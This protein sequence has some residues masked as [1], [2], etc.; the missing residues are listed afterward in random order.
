[1]IT[2]AAVLIWTVLGALA[3]FQGLLLLGAP[4]G[5]FAWGGQHR[6]LPVSL[7]IG[8][9]VSI[10]IYALISAVVLARVGTVSLGVSTDSVGMAIW[11]VA[12]YFFIVLGAESGFREQERTVRHARCFG[13]PLC[14]V[15]R[16]CSPLKC[17]GESGG[18]VVQSVTRATPKNRRRHAGDGTICSHRPAEA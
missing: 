2:S 6:V 8:S 7:P 1:M 17:L 5:R 10:V 9:L 11:V 18:S 4:L 12:A 3:L 14:A 13:G 15:H 16:R